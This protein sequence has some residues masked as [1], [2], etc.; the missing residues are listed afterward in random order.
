MIHNILP[1]G[2]ETKKEVLRFS[3]MRTSCMPVLQE[4]RAQLDE[5][6]KKNGRPEI[7][8][9]ILAGFSVL[10]L[11]ERLSDRAAV[12][13]CTYDLRWRYALDLPDDWTPFHPTTLVYF[14]YRLA[15]SGDARLILDVGLEAMQRSGYLKG[16]KAVR[17]DSTHMLG[18]IAI[19]NRLECVRETLRLALVFLA[20]F[21]GSDPWEPWFS[22]YADSNP[23]F[24]RDASIEIFR[25]TMK[26]AGVDMRDLLS[27]IDTLATVIAQAKPIA[28]LRRVF[29]EQFE[30]V[31][32]NVDDATSLPMAIP[33]LVPKK[34]TPAGGVST[35]HDPE[36][37][38]STKKSIDKKGWVGYKVQVCETAPEVPRE[39]GEPTIAIITAIVT[40]PAITSDNG[41]LPD[42]LAEHNQNLPKHQPSEVYTDAGYTSAPALNQ[43][44]EKGYELIGPIGAPPH[45]NTRFGSNSFKID[46]PNR[47]AICPNNIQNSAC[48]RIMAKGSDTASYYFEWPREACSICPL[49]SQCLSKKR[50]EKNRRTLEVSEHHMVVQKRRDLC[51]TEDYKLKMKRRNGIEGTNSELKRG[52]GMRRCRYK[53]LAKTDLQNQLT[54]AAC[55]LRRWASRLFWELSQQT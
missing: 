46:I 50:T 26:K 35:P 39:Q 49:K 23:E 20:E 29:K 21:G 34:S 37:T 28:L 43:A 55:N 38:W 8:P 1:E 53:G 30:V 12:E 47:I 3:L 32:S 7:D 33:E 36:A 10:Q 2:F 31:A 42:V 45:S 19:L 5:M 14:R 24:L 40:Q 48:S 15:D 6:Y 22:T 11:A 54:A 25:S 4:K 17:I 16:S 18:C 51:R 9:A 52:Y 41:S 44:E 13:A 27:R